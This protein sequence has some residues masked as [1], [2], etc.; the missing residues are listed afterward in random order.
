MRPLPE[1]DKR[2][3]VAG[4]SDTTIHLLEEMIGIRDGRAEIVWPIPG[5]GKLW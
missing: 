3:F 1:G 2:E 4:Y 5:R